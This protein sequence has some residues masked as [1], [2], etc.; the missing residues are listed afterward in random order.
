MLSEEINS[1]EW[2][3]LPSCLWV[4]KVVVIIPGNLIKASSCIKQVKDVVLSQHATS[5]L[6][7]GTLIFL[8]LC[9]KH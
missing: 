6:D 2:D 3:P 8:L 9:Y 1:I 5:H 7:G 4:M